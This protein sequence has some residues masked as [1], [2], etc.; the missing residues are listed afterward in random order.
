MTKSVPRPLPPRLALTI[1]EA[2][3]SIG[4]SDDFMREHVL[5]DLRVIRVGRKQLV[6]ITEIERWLKN[7]EA[8]TLD[9]Y[10]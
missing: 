1:T 3:A 2:A 7:H 10:R 9:A 6:S 4:V 8:L 5:N